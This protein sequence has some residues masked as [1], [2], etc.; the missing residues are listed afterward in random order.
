MGFGTAK[1]LQADRARIPFPPLG[2]PSRP[3]SPPSILRLAMSVNGY[4]LNKKRGRTK[5][6]LISLK[7]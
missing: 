7:G 5:K 3:F 1:G 2:F 4:L 6:S